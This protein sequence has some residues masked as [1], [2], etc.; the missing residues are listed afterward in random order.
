MTTP[1]AAPL[2]V[3]VPGMG[4]LRSEYRFFTP[5]L[6]QA[7]YRVVTMDVRG[8]GETKSSWPDVS[9]AAIGQDILALITHLD[10]GPAILAGNS[11][12]AGSAVCVAV[13]ALEKIRALIMPGPAVRGE[14]S[15]TMQFL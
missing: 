15:S 10:A 2:V 12:S 6:I 5:Q 9:I 11:F 8:H 13:E 4:D 3:C 7:G 1:A 14:V